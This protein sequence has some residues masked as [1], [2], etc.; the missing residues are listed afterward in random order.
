MIATSSATAFCKATCWAATPR[1]SL[2]LK[3]TGNAGGIHNLIVAAPGKAL[4]TQSFLTRMNTGC[5]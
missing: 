2:G 5:W 3:T 1:A 4:D